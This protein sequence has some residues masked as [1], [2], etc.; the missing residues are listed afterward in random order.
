[1][2]INQGEDQGRPG[3]CCRET[4]ARNNMAGVWERTESDEAALVIV[5]RCLLRDEAL[6]TI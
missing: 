3:T 5:S 6:R 4:A 1:M 2:F